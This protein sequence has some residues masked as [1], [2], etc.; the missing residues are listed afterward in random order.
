MVHDTKKTATQYGNAHMVY[1]MQTKCLVH[2]F[3]YINAREYRRG[4]QKWTIQRNCQHMAHKTKT[5]KKTNKQ[6][7]TKPKKKPTTQYMLD[8][9]PLTEYTYIIEKY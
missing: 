5:N 8:T 1:S 9:L 3:I 2:Y 6:N 4:N 7:K